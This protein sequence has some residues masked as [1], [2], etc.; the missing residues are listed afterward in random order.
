MWS[1]TIIIAETLLNT[2]CVQCPVICFL[3]VLSDIVVELFSVFRWIN[4]VLMKLHSVHN[5]AEPRHEVLNTV[6]HC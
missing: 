6:L 2:Y 1:K 5:Q 3:H 4:E